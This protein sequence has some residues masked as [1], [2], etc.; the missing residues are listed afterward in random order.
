MAE[1]GARMNIEEIKSFIAENAN[2]EDVQGLISEL[3][4]PTVEK[5]NREKAGLDR[6]IT[7]LKKNVGI[8]LTPEQAEKSRVILE[9]AAEL[10]AFEKRLKTREAG[11]QYAADNGIDLRIAQHFIKG[12]EEETLRTIDDMKQVLSEIV[13]PYRIDAERFRCSQAAPG[14]GD[15]QTWTKAKIARL[16]ITEQSRLYKSD[17]EF[18]KIYRGMYSR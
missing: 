3:T 7:E 13:E 8:T 5:L 15:A 18:R 16:S 2:S 10:E 4:A 17:P 9:K 14:G 11:L 12:D 6:T 1:K